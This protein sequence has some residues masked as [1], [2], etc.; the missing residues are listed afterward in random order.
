MRAMNLSY[1]TDMTD[2]QWDLIEG[3]LPTAKPGGRPRSVDL[4]AVVNA[5]FYIVVAGCAWRMLPHDFPKWKTV[6]SYFRAWREDGTWEAVHERLVL[7]LRVSEDREC[8]ATMG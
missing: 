8:L 3:L 6:Y 7:W 1:P 5:I 2:E 4:R